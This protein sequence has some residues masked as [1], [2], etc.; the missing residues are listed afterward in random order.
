MYNTEAVVIY[1]SD[2]EYRECINQVFC[3][4]LSEDEFFYDNNKIS[5]VLDA[6]YEKTKNNLL[7]KNLYER[8]AAQ[9]LSMDLEVGLASM[10]SYSYFDLFHCILCDILRYNTLDE[11]NIFYCKLL[12]LLTKN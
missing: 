11:S 2:E 3:I 10:F 12:K 9:F 4:E 6:I 7:F 5:G 1:S 8:G